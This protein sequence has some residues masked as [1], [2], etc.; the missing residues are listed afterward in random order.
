[1]ALRI[2]TPTEGGILRR[3]IVLRCVFVRKGFRIYLEDEQNNYLS[4][5]QISAPHAIPA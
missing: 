4:S 1:M 5:L 3:S 2:S